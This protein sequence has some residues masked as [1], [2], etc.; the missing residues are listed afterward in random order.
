MCARA[1]ARDAPAMRSKVTKSSPFRDPDWRRAQLERVIS[2]QARLRAAR[3]RS[4]RL[5][6]PLPPSPPPPQ[7]SR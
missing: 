6:P 4:S 1:G 5:L 7:A 2:E 3:M